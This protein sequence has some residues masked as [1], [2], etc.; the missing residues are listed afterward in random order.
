MNIAIIAD[1]R[2][3]MKPH[4]IMMSWAISAPLITSTLMSELDRIPTG[5]VIE[6]FRVT[7]DEPRAEEELD[8]A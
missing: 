3:G 7:L 6:H 2:K 5:S 8:L 4:P 1:I